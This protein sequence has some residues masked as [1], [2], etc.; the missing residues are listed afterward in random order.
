MKSIAIYGAGGF[1]KEVRGMLE[2]QKDI[3]SF[4]G[5]IDDFK[6]INEKPKGDYDVLLAI[7]DPKARIAIIEKW[8]DKNP[9]RSLIDPDI[10]LHPSVLIGRGSIICP[11][12]KFTVDITV[13]EFVILNLNSTV[14]HDSIIGDFAS[15][16]PSVNISGNVKIGMGSFIGSGATVLQGISIG[17]NVVIGAGSLVTKDVPPNCVVMGV[18]ARIVKQ[19]NA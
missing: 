5:F 1:G 6:E 17:D 10:R 12:V 13:G 4:A 3:F 16:M 2:M 7:A 15:I 19:H 18:P 14:G 11:G 9:F 8:S